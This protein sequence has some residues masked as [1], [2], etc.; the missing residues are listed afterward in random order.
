MEIETLD[1]TPPELAASLIRAGGGGRPPPGE[2][3]RALLAG[4]LRALRVGKAPA[5]K[6]ARVLLPGSFNPIH[7]G[8]LGMLRTA[9][10]L[11]GEMG[12][13][14][15]S[16]RNVDKP[17]L[18]E[19]EIAT[20][21]A[22]MPAASAVWLTRAPAF[23]EKAEL[24]PGACLAVGADTIVRVAD[25][26]YYGGDPARAEAAVRHLRDRGIRFLVFGRRL[27][28]PGTG[29]LSGRSGQPPGELQADRFVELEDLEL[30][31]A[32][33][34]L[35]TGVPSRLFREDISSSDLRALERGAP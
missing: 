29:S 30:P 5:P 32:L 9:R 31:D 11:L 33:A 28:E 35:C 2:A 24:F 15:L 27:G 10:E 8:H 6:G 17:P 3:V 16:L 4:E 21:L 18:T 22:R 14:E 25:P 20:R 26:R 34:R 19:R 13:L 1:L 7:R 23:T 12:E